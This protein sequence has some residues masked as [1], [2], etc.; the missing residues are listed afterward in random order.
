MVISV[1]N[2]NKKIKNNI[3]LNDISVNF[4]SKKIY[5]IKGKNGSGKTMLL[6]AISGLTKIDTGR[7]II[8]EK[9]LGKDMD[10]PDSIGILIDNSGFPG[11]LNAFDNLKVISSIK[12]IISDDEITEAIDR[13]GLLNDCNKKYRQYSLGMKQKLGIAAAIMEKP[14]ILLL[15]EP[16]NGLDQESVGKLQKILQEERA[17]GALIIIVSHDLEELENISDEIYQ[18][19]DGCVEKI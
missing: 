10:F 9:E 8:G 11:G 17:R 12:N 7:I 2:V 18:M 4:E 19:R 14:D 3:I 16:T 1:K 15:D 6:K 13:V 5:G